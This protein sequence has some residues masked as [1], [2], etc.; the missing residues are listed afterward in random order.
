MQF[1]SNIYN[2]KHL[3]HWALFILI[4]STLLLH[5]MQRPDEDDRSSAL[6]YEAQTRCSSSHQSWFPEPD[7]I[8]LLLMSA[9][10]KLV[11]C[12]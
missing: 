1:L 2:C 10:F 5:R 4:Q 6:R 11:Q 12:P 8:I 3:Y 7:H 9:S